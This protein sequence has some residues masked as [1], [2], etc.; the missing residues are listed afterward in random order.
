MY[1]IYKDEG[2]ESLSL[3][4]LRRHVVNVIFLKYSKKGRLCLSH[5][6]IRNIPSDLCYDDTKHYL[7]QSEHSRTHDPFGQLRGSVFA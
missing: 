2:D 5:L 3:L 4:A 1:R 6:G 7:V